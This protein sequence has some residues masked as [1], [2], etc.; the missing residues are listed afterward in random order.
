MK[1]VGNDGNMPGLLSG[2]P[3]EYSLLKFQ[4]YTS[5]AYVSTSQFLSMFTRQYLK[6]MVKPLVAVE[7]GLETN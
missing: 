2:V 6:D 3:V 5:Y 7:S 4:T 1:D